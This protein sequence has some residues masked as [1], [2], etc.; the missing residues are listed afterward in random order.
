[1]APADRCVSS[2]ITGPS[3]TSQMT[4]APRTEIRP[5]AER[6]RCRAAV[7]GDGPGPGRWRCPEGS[8]PRT[9]PPAAAAGLAAQL[10]LYRGWYRAGITGHDRRGQRETALL[11][12]GQTGRRKGVL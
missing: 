1:M 9:A 2:A 7:P 5:D 8:S 11:V 10:T 3:S 4:S 12:Q 6:T